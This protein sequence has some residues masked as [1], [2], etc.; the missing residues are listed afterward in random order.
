[1]VAF[2]FSLPSLFITNHILEAQNT[3][4]YCSG[5]SCHKPRKQWTPFNNRQRLTELRVICT[6]AGRWGEPTHQPRC[7]IKIRHKQSRKDETIVFKWP[8]TRHKIREQTA[9]RVESRQNGNRPTVSQVSSRGS[10]IQN[11]FNKE[12]SGS[13]D[14]VS[15]STAD[16]TIYDA[17]EPDED[18]QFR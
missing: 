12:E 17:I 2:R 7:F 11:T 6:T 5:A 13:I 9:V 8:L 15:V 14:S 4:A 3:L 10:A 1:M 16:V 18:L